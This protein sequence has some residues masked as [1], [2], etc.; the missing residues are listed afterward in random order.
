M[1]TAIRD[2]KLPLLRQ[3]LP[4]ITPR[5]GRP[6]VDVR[7]AKTQRPLILQGERS[8]VN[9]FDG[10]LA[11][12]SGC[13]YKCLYCYMPSVLR[14][15]PDK[16]GGWGNYLDSR[17]QSIEWIKRHLEE[18]EGAALFLSATTDPYNPYE[19]RFG[20]TR[21]LLEVLAGSKMG[22]LLIS[23]RGTLV[24]RDI[25]LF[26]DARMRGRIEVGVS[27][28]SNLQAVH[29]AIEP[30]T[31]S[32]ARRFEVARKLKEAGIPVRIHA[33]PMALHSE[34]FYSLAAACANW[35]WI[36]EPQHGADCHPRLAHWFYTDEELHLLVEQAQ[37]RPG[38]GP[39]RVG[40][41]KARFGWRWDSLREAIVPPPPRVKFPPKNGEGGPH[42]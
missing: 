34:D 11:T 32:F 7:E 24:E 33:A 14:G 12:Y 30:Y 2:E 28:P 3:A 17:S 9:H 36:D 6:K 23:T 8:F 16:Q 41:G 4:P 22:F 25:D 39:S 10:T 13:P 19:A 20:L 5:E 35:L 38:L 21:R 18:I 42:G 40:F 31:P 15:L 26:T 37:A 29:S 27:L 1:N